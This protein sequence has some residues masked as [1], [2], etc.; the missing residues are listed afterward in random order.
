MLCTGLGTP[1]M[2]KVTIFDE[3]TKQSR[4]IRCQYITYE[5]VVPIDIIEE[6]SGIQRPPK[7]MECHTG[8]NSCRI[9]CHHVYESDL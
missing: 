8:R 3:I 6:D 5:P 9:G 7:G 4:T 1:N 2:M